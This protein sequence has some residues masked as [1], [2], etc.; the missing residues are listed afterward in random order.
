MYDTDVL[1]VGAGPTGLTLAATLGALPARF[2]FD[3]RQL[4]LPQYF[5]LARGNAAQPAIA[6]RPLAEPMSVTSRCSDRPALSE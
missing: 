1:I 3:A 4:S 5:E 6:I 2:G